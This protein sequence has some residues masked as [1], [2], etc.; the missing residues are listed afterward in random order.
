[1]S[2]IYLGLKL[3]EYGLLG[4]FAVIILF[5]IVI[6]ILRKILPYRNEDNKD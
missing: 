2:D 1:M 6:L 4:T 3:M 5:Y